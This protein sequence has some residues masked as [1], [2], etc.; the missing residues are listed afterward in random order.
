MGVGVGCVLMWMGQ[1]RPRAESGGRERGNWR[2]LKVLCSGCSSELA[3]VKQKG[4]ATRKAQK[5]QK[6][7]QKLEMGIRKSQKETKHT[8]KG[9]ERERPRDHGTTGPRT[10]DHGPRGRQ[11]DGGKKMGTAR[12]RT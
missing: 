2:S 4:C 6:R 5:G 12:P 1:G 3:I 11:E 10:T 9:E 8:K 7:N